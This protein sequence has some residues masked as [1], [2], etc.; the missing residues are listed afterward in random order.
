M[1]GDHSDMIDRAYRLVADLPGVELSNSWG[2]PALKVN[3]KTFAG[4]SREPR[5]LFISC[6][7][8]MKELLIEA[9]PDVFF[10]TD[11]YRGWPAILVR[12]DAADDETLR[13]RLEAAWE[14]KAPKKVVRVWRQGVGV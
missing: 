4:H 6:P 13:A 7:L 12:V 11:H 3:G 8:E 1:T 14:N 10:E 9:D 2:R 5:A